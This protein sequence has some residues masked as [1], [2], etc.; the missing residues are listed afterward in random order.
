MSDEEVI[1]RRLLIDG[2]GTGDDRRLNVFLKTIIKWANSIDESP[3]ELQLLYD[4][5]LAQ[6]SQCEF[7][8]KRSQRLAITNS[9]QLENYKELQCKLEELIK[10]VKETIEHSKNNLMQ[11]KILKQNRMTYDLLA[12][13]IKQQPARKETNKRL[14]ELKIELGQLHENSKSLENKLDMRRKQFHVL[15]SSAHQLKEMLEESAAE[16]SANNSLDDITNSP[17]PEPMSE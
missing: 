17:G 16:D 4:R 13:N 10:D 8:V 9:K 11:A 5:L 12:Q 3:T 15:V 7:A 2:D 6:L 14:E 1:R